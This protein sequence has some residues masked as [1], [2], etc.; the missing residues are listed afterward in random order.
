MNS[1]NRSTVEMNAGFAAVCQLPSRSQRLNRLAIHPKLARD[2]LDPLAALLP[3]DD[4]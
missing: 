2:P 3:C 1:A 4:L